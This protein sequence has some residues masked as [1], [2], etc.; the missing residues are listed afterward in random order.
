MSKSVFTA[1]AALLLVS[2]SS[3][4]AIV[5]GY[6]VAAG[7]STFPNCP[8]F[9]VGGSNESDFDGGEFATSAT[10]QVNNATASGFASG[11][12]GGSAFTPV[13]RA[14]ADSPLHVYRR[15]KHKLLIVC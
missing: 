10:A 7:A 14:S 12:F 4:A 8:S 11:S 2:V 15:C 9:C 3:H 1:A 6:G 5:P 13:L